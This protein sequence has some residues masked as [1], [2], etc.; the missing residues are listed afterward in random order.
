MHKNT[1]VHSRKSGADSVEHLVIGQDVSSIVAAPC[2][3]I[4]KGL[5]DLRPELFKKAETDLLATS[6]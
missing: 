2:S 4:A 1:L 6:T 5:G 3:V